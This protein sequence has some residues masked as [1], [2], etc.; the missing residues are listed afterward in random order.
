MNGYLKL[1]IEYLHLHPHMGILFTFIIAFLE[2]LPL[3]GTLVPGSV[4]MTAIG[5]LLGTGVLPLGMTLAWA[6]F[7]AFLG[8]CVGFWIG[9]RYQDR[10]LKIWP[11]N[12]HPKWITISENFFKKHGGKSVIIGR[13]AGPVRSTIPLAAGLL[14]LSWPRFMLAAAPSAI[15]WAILYM[16]PG[17]LLGAL[18]MELPPSKMTAFIL[19]GLGVIIGIWIILW[20]IQKSFKHLGR[21]LNIFIDRCWKWLKQHHSSQFFI[22]LITNH[23]HPGDHFQLTLVLLALISFIFFLILFINVF[24]KLSLTGFNQPLFLFF[25]KSAH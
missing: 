22:R 2:S 20:I 12:K 10:L 5:T 3:V 13:F 17:I 18:S 1:M 8:D 15:L 14:Q 24:F 23:Q 4:T 11:F 9:R 16:V 6:M 19:T 25:P 7:G 21:Y